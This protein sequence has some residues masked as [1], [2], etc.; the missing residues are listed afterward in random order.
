MIIAASVRICQ[1]VLGLRRQGLNPDELVRAMPAQG[2]DHR[3]R[4]RRHHGDDQA[5]E[6]RSKSKRELVKTALGALSGLVVLASF[7]MRQ[8]D[9]YQ[10]SVPTLDDAPSLDRASDRFFQFERFGRVTAVDR[11]QAWVFAV[12][13]WSGHCRF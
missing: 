9:K 13:V 7:L 4:Q 11:G 2:R 3:L 5:A 10:L 6:R 12:R 8:W 1:W